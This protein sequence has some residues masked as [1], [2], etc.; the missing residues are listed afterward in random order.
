MVF[1]FKAEG[2]KRLP[3]R[4]PQQ[5]R[6]D[7]R[8]S[9]KIRAEMVAIIPR[10][11]R[12]VFTLTGNLDDTDDIVQETCLRALARLDQWQSGTKLD[13]WMYRIAQNIWIDRGRA[14]RVRGVPI[15]LAEDNQLY[16]I[17]GRKTMDT[18]LTL[19]DALEGIARLPAEQRILIALICVNGCSYK[20]AAHITK[21]PIGT[22][23]SRLARARSALHEFLA[24]SDKKASASKDG[25]RD[26]QLN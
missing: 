8:V 3:T 11:R 26:A 24:Q 5:W 18:R 2:I 13:S 19:R 10:L 23:M 17:D 25:G 16:S 12:F 20:E 21:I 14:T 9:D 7:E 4:Y 15:D 6:K 22:I 1:F